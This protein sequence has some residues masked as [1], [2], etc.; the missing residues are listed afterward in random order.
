MAPALTLHPLHQR[1]RGVLIYYPDVLCKVANGQNKDPFHCSSCNAFTLRS[2]SLI[3]LVLLAHQLP[4]PETQLPGKVLVTGLSNDF[5]Q[6]VQMQ[7]KLPVPV[8]STRSISNIYKD[9]QQSF[10]ASCNKEKN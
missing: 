6:H 5:I 3:P 4:R 10:F 9:L 8:E 2:T 1:G 7:L